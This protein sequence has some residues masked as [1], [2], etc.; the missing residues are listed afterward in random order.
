MILHAMMHRQSFLLSEIAKRKCTS[1]VNF[2]IIY[3]H[4]REFRENF[5]RI[6]SKF[7]F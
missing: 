7:F 1:L 4:S 5:K 2:I 3:F 6:F